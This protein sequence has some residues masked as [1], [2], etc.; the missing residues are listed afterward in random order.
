MATF[1]KRTTAPATTDPHY[2]SD[3]PFYQS[4]YGLPNCTCYAWGR[5]YELSGS[6]PSLS[7]RDAENWF[8]YSDGYERGQIPKLGAVICWRRG[9]TGDDSDG[10]GHVAIVEEISADGSIVTS[11][12]AW[13]STLF[14]LQ[15]LTKES[16]YTWNDAYT[17]QGFIYNPVNFEGGSTALPDPISGNR[18]L[19]LAEMQINATYIYYYLNQRG[20]TLNAIAGMLGNMETESSINPGI[21]ESLN[22]GYTGGGFGLVQWTPATNLITWAEDNGL[23]Y[24]AMDTQLKRII[25]ELDNNLQYY[26]TTAYPETFSEFKTSTKDPAYLALAFLANYER[27]AD[28][29]QPIRGEQA[30]YWYEYLSGVG[31]IIPTP[32][33]K[34]KKRRYNFLLFRRRN[35]QW[36]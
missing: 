6:R 16:G 2:Y 33:I 11:N 25:Y 32:G 18:W 29:N 28:P 35:R 7:L 34:K 9:N 15:T 31:P 12:S 1:V 27:P 10:S 36:L 22:E 13:G 19:T 3:N 17:F 20:W 26:P 8:G 5:F 30:Q 14:Y 21:W 23:E 4:G 24:A